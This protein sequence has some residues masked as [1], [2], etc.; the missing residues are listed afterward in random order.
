VLGLTVDEARTCASQKA[1]RLAK[2]AA[3]ADAATA[4]Q[5][6]AYAIALD[7]AETQAFQAAQR[8]ASNAKIPVFKKRKAARLAKQRAN[9]NLERK[10]QAVYPRYRS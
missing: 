4:A 9:A 5:A 6:Q 1:V 2:T 7:R 3:K 10:I 8:A